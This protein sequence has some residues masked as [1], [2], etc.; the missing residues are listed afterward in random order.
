[1]QSC[2]QGRRRGVMEVTGGGSSQVAAW[3]E[4]AQMLRS[5]LSRPLLLPTLTLTDNRWTLKTRGR[6]R[7]SHSKL[8]D[9]LT[10]E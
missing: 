7:M 6:R 8:T 5:I 1:M 3:T 9:T 10:E 4:R 2:N